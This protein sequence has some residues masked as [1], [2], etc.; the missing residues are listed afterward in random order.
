MW[1]LDL[2]Q[3]HRTDADGS[4]YSAWVILVCLRSRTALE[5]E[6]RA[7]H[8]DIEQLLGEHGVY[9]AEIT[10][11]RG[12]SEVYSKFGFREG[13][14]PL[15]LVLNQHPLDYHK[16]DKLLVIEWGKWPDVDSLR[17]LPGP[18]R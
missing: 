15:F 1:K 11:S 12:K 5:D 2:H 7:R 6:V 18:G 4:T 14:H 16:G 17:G 3:V 8:E 10:S 13:S 9:Y